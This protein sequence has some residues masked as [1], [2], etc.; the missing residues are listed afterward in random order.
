MP[1]R[2]NET[3]ARTGLRDQLA[4]VAD[5]HGYYAVWI[6]DNNQVTTKLKS[7]CRPL[8]EQ[9]LLADA[10]IQ[11]LNKEEWLDGQWI[12]AW[13]HPT[14][15][16]LVPQE[17][18]ALWKDADGDTPFCVT[19]EWHLMQRERIGV[20]EIVGQCHQAHQEWRQHEADLGIT[21]EQKRK[22]AQGEPSNDPTQEPEI[23]T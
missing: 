10:A 13:T 20:L 23:P 7:P 5:M 19:F 9:Q 22:R 14:T 8:I 3:A 1:F 4:D 12:I 16:D 6:G 17:L 2:P 15:F 21:P 18:Q 11:K